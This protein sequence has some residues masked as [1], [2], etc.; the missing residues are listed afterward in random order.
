MLD[1]ILKIYKIFENPS[2]SYYKGLVLF[3]LGLWVDWIRNSVWLFP[4]F[5][6]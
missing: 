5:M 2:L 4:N 6:S 3:Q 1:L